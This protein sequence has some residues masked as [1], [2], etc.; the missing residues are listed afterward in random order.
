MPNKSEKYIK[1]SL[2]GGIRGMS[3][4]T[5]APPQYEDQRKQYGADV[6]RRFI[7]ERAY[8]SSDFVSAEVQ[9][10]TENFYEYVTTN[11]RLSDI[12]SPR[13]SPTRRV[14]DFKEILFVDPKIAYI[15]IGAKIKT[16]GSTWLVINPS[17]IASSQTTAVVARCNTSYNSYDSFGNIVTE[18]IYIE[19]A[20]MLGNDDVQRQN[21]IL[22]DGYFNVTCQ[23][24]EN[25]Q[26]LG[27]NQRIILGNKPYHITGFTDF[28]QEFSGN[29]ESVRLL[30]FTVRLEENTIE[31]D[32]DENYIASGNDFVYSVDVYGPSYLSSSTSGQLY[33]TLLLNG[34]EVTEIDGNSIDW[35][36]KS[37]NDRR[38][39]VS[40]DGVITVN[41]N[42]LGVGTYK[43]YAYLKGNENLYGEIE[44]TVGDIPL[45]FKVAFLGAFPTSIPQYQTVVYEAAFFESE[46]QTE[47]P[48]EFSFSGA[49]EGSYSA[50]VNGNTVSVTCNSYSATPLRITAK[51]YDIS[52][53][54]DVYLEG[55]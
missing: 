7:G 49:E 51:N 14:D 21:L 25:T 11:I 28:I 22:M 12:E 15:P 34:E 9:G 44:L 33:A 55:Y 48:L 4:S 39:T 29:R 5:N 46:S 41:P 26:K 54:I 18:P 17:N 53:Y 19:R 37:E 42:F 45:V 52:T 24:N 30:T 27:H 1:T 10:I 38:I 50:T 16:M 23:L 20:A 36:W 6:S 2:Y 43:V 40:D 32:T 35:I 47:I 13:V 31:D 8:L 3:Y